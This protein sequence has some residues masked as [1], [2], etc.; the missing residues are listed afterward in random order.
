M[1]EQDQREYGQA[2]RRPKSRE[3][4][5]RLPWSN[6]DRSGNSHNPENRVCSNQEQRVPS[7]L[8]GD[9]PSEIR[10][11]QNNEKDWNHRQRIAD[12][13]PIANDLLFP[14]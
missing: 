10:Q 2:Q 8:R 7:L 4:L 14:V 5:H 12:A 1:Q 6:P 9:R 11:C 13:V 3:N